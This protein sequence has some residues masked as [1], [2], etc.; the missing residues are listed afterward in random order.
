MVELNLHSAVASFWENHGEILAL[1]HTEIL[2]GSFTQEIIGHF[3]CAFLA[4]FGFC[5]GLNPPLKTL[6]WSGVFAAVG[7]IS[8]AFKPF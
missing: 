2:Q 6:V 7:H 3:I 1:L 4:G 5:Y 8:L